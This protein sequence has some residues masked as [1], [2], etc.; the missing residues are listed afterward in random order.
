[1]LAIRLRT[2]TLNNMPTDVVIDGLSCPLESPPTMDAFAARVS[3]L[4]AA[5]RAIYPVG[6][7]SGLDFGTPPSQAGVALSL[8]QLNRV[9][10]YPVRD[11]TITVEAGITV[12]EVQDLLS[13]QNQRL[14]V[15]VPHPDR[16]TLGGAVS[17]NAFGPRRLSCGTFRDHV[18]GVTVVNDNGELCSAGGRVVKNVAGYD[19]AKL[20]TGALG[21]LG[22]IV[23]LTLKIQPLPPASVWVVAPVSAAQLA[24]TLDRMHASVTRPAAV[25]VLNANAVRGMSD[26]S[27]PAGDFV[28]AVLY[29]DNEEAVEWQ[30]GQLA[31]E[32]N[33]NMTRINDAVQF[34]RWLVDSPAVDGCDFSVLATTRPSAVAEILDTL[35]LGDNRL[36]AHA[37][38]GVIHLGIVSPEIDRATQIHRL[39]LDMVA[40]LAGNAIIRRCQ[41]SWKTHL[42]VWGRPPQ[43][44]SLMQNVKQQFDPRNL[45]NPGRHR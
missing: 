28:L 23:Q 33:T 21:T 35:N 18:I 19:L 40:K 6:G 20:Y 9:I 29:E 39:A 43:S 4:L 13:A 26:A 22:I 7:G 45:F 1:M 16:A 11:L 38:S 32:L 15:E 3:E 36:H 37:M 14:P 30:I 2:D 42:G 10:D 8:A 5:G 41:T 31:T 25:D 34:E 27:L 17:T 24:V 12:A 44:L